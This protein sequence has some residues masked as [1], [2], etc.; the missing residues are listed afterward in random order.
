MLNYLLPASQLHL[1]KAT[2]YVPLDVLCDI[3]KLQFEKLPPPPQFR[4]SDVHVDL[5]QNLLLRFLLQHH[6]FFHTCLS[7]KD[8]LRYVCTD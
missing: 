4:G 6:A 1:R 3:L 8:Q 2:L 7:A 5:Y